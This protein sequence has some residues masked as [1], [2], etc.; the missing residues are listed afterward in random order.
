M[1]EDLSLV[2]LIVA[3]VGGIASFV[4]PCVLPL[5][6]IFLGHLSGVSVKDGQIQGGRTTFFHS[7]G[8]VIGF[9]IPFIILGATVGVLGGTAGGYGDLI[10]RIAGALLMAVGLYMAGAFRLPIVRNVLG[11]VN[12]WLDGIYFRE[13]RIHVGGEDAPPSYWRSALVGGAFGVGWTPCITPLLG[14]ILTLA[15][16]EAGSSINAWGAAGEAAI[17]LA[18][19]TAG[20]SIPFLV[21]G[22]A[23]GQITPIFRK[24][25]RYLPAIT[26][27]SG[28]LMVLIGVLVFFNQLAKLNDYFSFLERS[29]DAVERPLDASDTFVIYQSLGLADTPGDDAEA[30]RGKLAPN[31][32]FTSD[33]G[34]EFSLAE[35]R[36][37]PVIVNFWATWCG[38]CR[39]EMPDLQRV[40][41]TLGDE[42]TLLA[43]DLDE[44]PEAVTAFFDELGLAL[45][46]VIDERRTIADQGYGLF[47]VPSTYVIDADG[48]IVATK[49]GPYADLEEINGHLEELGLHV[50][51]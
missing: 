7:V 37:Q 31:F 35:L 26:V 47:G 6:P 23:L 49:I 2:S 46:V 48:V 13:R 12:D 21:T 28:I 18:F 42:L 34:E 32:R 25:N 41:D 8:F 38:P 36:G 51:E 22:A 44:T 50:E 4:S 15:F 30:V 40:H 1:I 5:V 27:A 9:S 19:Y 17:L 14:A 43:V 11:P 10:A 33:D 29:P 20:L 45:N 16:N 24:L 3:F 39:A